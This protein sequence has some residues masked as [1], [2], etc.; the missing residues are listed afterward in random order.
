MAA[1]ASAIMKDFMVRL[2]SFEGKYCIDLEELVLA[3]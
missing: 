3:V 1:R 2:I